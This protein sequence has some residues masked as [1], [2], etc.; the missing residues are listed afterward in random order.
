MSK[1]LNRIDLEDRLRQAVEDAMAAGDRSLL[2][3]ALRDLNSLILDRRIP[4]QS[5]EQNEKKAAAS[6]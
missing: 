3:H 6:C 4:P 1:P 5:E 2:E